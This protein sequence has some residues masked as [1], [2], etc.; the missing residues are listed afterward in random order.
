MKYEKR[1]IPNETFEI[2][3]DSSNLKMKAIF[4]LLRYTGLRPIEILSLKKENINFEKNEIRVK[5]RKKTKKVIKT[6]HLHERA[7]KEL[8]NYTKY[9]NPQGNYIFP[10]RYNTSQHF[11]HMAVYEYLKR[12]CKKLNLNIQIRPYEFRRK[13]A[14]DIYKNSKH[15]IKLTAQALNHNNLA[16]VHHY[17]QILDLEREKNI[18]ANFN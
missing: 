9:L 8:L 12:K 15:D 6:K 11:S 1:Y 13:F 18:I 16:S 5:I 17:I 7:K 3:M 2:L 10:G 14:L 4:S